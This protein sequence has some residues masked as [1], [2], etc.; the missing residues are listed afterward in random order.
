MRSSSLLLL[1][2]AG[3]CAPAESVLTQTGAALSVDYY[4]D[5]DVVGMHFEV[6]PCDGGEVIELNVDLADAIYP[7]MVDVMER[8]LD[9]ASRHLGADLFLS[10]PPGCYDILAVP[11]SEIDGEEWSPSVDCSSASA[12]EIEVIG[13]QTTEVEP[14]VSQCVGDPLGSVD[15]TVVLNHPPSVSLQIEQTTNYECEPVRICATIE[16]VDDDP[17]EVEWQDLSQYGWWS[18]DEGELEIVGFEA[19]HRVWEVCADI[20]TRWTTAY[21]F[22]L[23]AYDLAVLEGESVRMSEVV[24]SGDSSGSMDFTIRTNWIEDPMCMSGD[25]A[26]PVEGAEIERAEGCGYTS[27]ETFYCSGRYPVDPAVAQFLCDEDGHLI[28]SAL[29]PECR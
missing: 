23:A 14:L 20:V 18:I 21:E 1:L 19:G 25:E 4:G 12:S 3:A 6:A 22:G 11:A 24:D 5:T 29:Y 8:R 15:L 26:V 2:A 16:D 17:I 28:E 10:L 7:G 27:A 9:P 13:G